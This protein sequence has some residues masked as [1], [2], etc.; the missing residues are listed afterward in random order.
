MK[1]DDFI[2]PFLVPPG[3]KISLRKD[4]DPATRATT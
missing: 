4:Y 2:R 3:K 1:L